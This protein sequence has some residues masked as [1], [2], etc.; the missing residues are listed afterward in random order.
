MKLGEKMNWYW[1]MFNII[2][3]LTIITLFTLNVAGFTKYTRV[4]TLIEKNQGSHS[5]KGR[6]YGDYYFTVIWKDRDKESEVFEVSG[7]T[8]F[9][10]KINESV[11]F[12]RTK[13]EYEKF[14]SGW[15]AFT[16]ATCASL[17]FICGL[18]RILSL[19][20]L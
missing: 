8:Y 17:W 5:Y 19:F 10:S 20:E 9:G 1:L 15:C 14:K 2:L 11:Y 18:Y 16:M 6:C 7:E 4:G 12:K 3:I 13:P